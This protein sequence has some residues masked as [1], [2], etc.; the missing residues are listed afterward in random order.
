MAN[1]SV[2]D[3]E[4]AVVQLGRSGKGQRAMSDLLALL[5]NGG[6]SLD[7]ENQ[8]HVLRL[9]SGAWGNYAGTTLEA[10]R[11]V[12]KPQDDPASVEAVAA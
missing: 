12:V 5:E 7:E 1:V 4:R 9:L 10:L 3:L 11:A 6:I 8:R 2:E